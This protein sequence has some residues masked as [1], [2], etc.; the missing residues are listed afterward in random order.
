MA[1]VLT[2][3]LSGMLAHQQML[4]VTANNI[5][6]SETYGF[7]KSRTDF[8]DQLYWLNSGA[9]QPGGSVG[10]KDPSQTGQGVQT[11]AISLQW[12]QG[13]IQSTGRD[14]DLSITGEALFRLQDSAGVEH[15]SR[16]G[17][18]GFDSGTP[19]KLVDLGTGMVVINSQGE[20]IVPV[21]NIAAAATTQLVLSGN[22]PPKAAVP[23]QGSSLSSLFSLR[24]TTGIPVTGATRLSDTTLARSQPTGPV[25]L[26]VFGNAPDGV[27][28]NGTVTLAP[29][30][31]VQD[32]ITGLNRVLQRSTAPA[33]EAIATVSLDAGNLRATGALPGDSFRLFL[34]EQPPPATG[35]TTVD[36]N[37][38]QYGGATDVYAW[39]RMRFT[40]QSI[41]STLQLYTADGSQHQLDARW[42]NAAT[43][44]TGTG[45]P[46]DYQRVWDLIMDV[47]SGGT[48]AP[49]GDSLR[50]L[51]FNT[52]G[53]QL[54]APTGSLVSTWTV[55]GASS[56][57]FD[58]M[59]LRGYQGDAVADSS[60]GTGY[61]TGA[62]QGIT[63]DA[64]GTLNGSYSNGKTVPMS[65][66]GHQ[67]GL[68]LFANPSGLL[69]EGRN[70]WRPTVNSGTPLNVVGGANGT[71][72]IAAG[73]LEGSN[74]DVS[75]EFTRLIVAQR[76]FQA[77]SKS[78]QTGDQM[79]TEAF[80][81]FR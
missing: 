40:P 47:P 23:L 33:T 55:G 2:T 57:T 42:Y 26:N 59:L 14:L 36:L 12:Q 50:G 45:Q 51:T 19:R 9:Q 70:L 66:T 35:A 37:T 58:T 53:T 39:S 67:L 49:G 73:T 7:K 5:A 41:P 62:L 46:T 20:Q 54:A 4:D 31:T 56:L 15:Y 17:N 10:G 52:D 13:G 38:W 75:V 63:V 8:S 18:F 69:A 80:S 48:L 68:A 72:A 65:A 25:T 24:S 64:T 27:P 32:L 60:D 29:G 11:A 81:L 61:P 74:V 21:D 43:V 16:V 28:Y 78:F 30:A 34:G 77:N 1:S 76:G 79:L 44:S 6:N 3:S 22:L 71:N